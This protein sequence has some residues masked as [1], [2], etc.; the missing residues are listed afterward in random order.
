MNGICLELQNVVFL[1][2]AFLAFVVPGKSKVTFFCSNGN[3]RRIS[4]QNKGSIITRQIGESH[5]SDNLGCGWIIDAGVGK[6]IKLTVSNLDLQ[7]AASYAL[8]SG[9]DHLSI[10]DGQTKSAK[11]LLD[12]CYSTNPYQL[13]S[14]G[15]YFYLYFTSND[16]NFYEHAGVTLDFEIYACLNGI[17]GP[18]YQRSPERDAKDRLMAERMKDL[19]T[20]PNGLAQRVKIDPDLS[21]WA[22]SEFVKMDASSIYDHK[23]M[24]NAPPTGNLNQR[25]G[26][27]GIRPFDFGENIAMVSKI[28]IGL[29]DLRTE[30]TYQWLDG[31][32]TYLS[33]KMDRFSGSKEK[34]CV[35][36][37]FNLR[38]WVAKNCENEKMNYL[39][40]KARVGQ[41]TVYSVPEASDDDS[42]G[43]NV[44]MVWAIVLA[45]IGGVACVALLIICYFC[46][47]K[48]KT[49]RRRDYRAPNRQHQPNIEEGGSEQQ[50]RSNSNLSLNHSSQ[51]PTAPPINMDGSTTLF[52]GPEQGPPPSYEESIQH[53]I[54]K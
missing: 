7:W 51:V 20:T 10:R 18:I 27:F 31:S 13:L 48:K 25:R 43:G 41:T 38:H 36:H 22:R 40:A 24:G 11:L 12:I 14:S 29:N 34:D 53:Q 52:W 9:Y 42:V 46:H 32:E 4:E 6:R 21:R 5:Y 15:Q 45:V 30:G 39:C 28:W 23:G 2:L 35:I 3:I 17:R 19:L 50:H 37:D 16:K 26:C 8:C 54:A 1:T 47:Q 44:T 49:P 33:E